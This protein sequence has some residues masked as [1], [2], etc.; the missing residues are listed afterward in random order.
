MKPKREITRR[1]SIRLSAL[2]AAGVS[3]KVLTGDNELVTGKIAADLKSRYPRLRLFLSTTTIAGQQ[4]AARQIAEADAT[5]YFPID[6][7]IIVR[8]TLRLVRP[9]LFV[10]METEIWPNLWREARRFWE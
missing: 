2:A 10:V 7:G 8:R 5:F 4:V 3:V 6:L 9:R 1:E